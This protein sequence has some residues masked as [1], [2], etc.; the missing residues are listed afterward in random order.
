MLIT[1]F[2]LLNYVLFR[3]YNKIFMINSIKEIVTITNAF[4]SS[5]T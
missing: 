5:K 3:A 4:L 2:L 1:L